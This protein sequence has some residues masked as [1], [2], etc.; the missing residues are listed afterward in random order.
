[1]P[2]KPE[3]PAD[4]DKNPEWAEEDFARARPFKNGFP[5]QYEAWTKSRA[6]QPAVEQSK[7]HIGLH[8]AVDVVEGV[9]ATGPGYDARVEK[10]LR[11][12]RA[13]GQL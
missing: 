9:R 2:Y 8:L 11:E 3:P 4:F 12:A 13:K 7:V 10:V 1:M 6:G 5:E